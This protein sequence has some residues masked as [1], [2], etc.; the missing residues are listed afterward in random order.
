MPLKLPKSSSR[1]AADTDSTMFSRDL[2]L[3]V[4]KANQRD[5]LIIRLLAAT[6]INPSELAALRKEDFSAKKKQIILRSE[7]TK[8]GQRRVLRISKA[9]CEDLV[10]YC[11]K[12][13]KSLYLFSTRQSPQLTVRRIEQVFKSASKDAKL[14]VPITPRDLRRV[15][16][17]QAAKSTSSD[18]NLKKLTG[19][20][21]INKKDVLSLKEETKLTKAAKK[22][23]VR[24]SALLSLILELP[25]SASALTQLKKKDIA[26]TSLLVGTRSLAIS[27]ALSLQLSQLVASKNPDEFIFSTRQ[28]PSLTVRRVEQLIASYGKKVGIPK[29]TSLKIK[30]SVV[31]RLARELGAKK[32]QEIAGYKTDLLYTHG[33]PKEYG[34][35][36][37]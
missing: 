29:L 12:A 30:A 16:I 31:E 6:G 36:A 13:S 28:S 18:K 26:K 3:L 2:S 9:L 24:D 33:I 21:S 15:Y 1:K 23:S 34:G 32:A 4:S 10:S 5:S 11:M 20:K 22:A 25:L 27:S 17:L 35:E 37:T 7:D 8:H 19:L 14:K